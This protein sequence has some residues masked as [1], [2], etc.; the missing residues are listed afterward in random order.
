MDMEQIAR[1][2]QLREVEVRNRIWMSPMAQY[3]ATGDGCLTEWHLLHYG[4]RAVGGVGMVMVESTAIGPGDR[5]T[6]VDPGIWSEAQVDSHRKV[7]DVIRRAGAVPA[8]QLQ[9]AGRK[10]SHRVPWERSGQNSPVAPEE[11]GWIPVAPS[12]IPFGKL[13]V[14]RV[15]QRAEISMVID[16]FARAAVNAHDAGYDVVEVHA[17][18]GYLLHQFLSPLSNRRVDEYGGSLENRMRFPLAA[19]R[20]VRNEFPSNKPVF[21]RVSTND[22]ASGGFDLAEAIEFAQC[23]R[24]L[25]IDLLDV[26]SGG[27]LVDAPPPPKPALNVKSADRIRQDAGIRVAPVGQIGD[28]SVL[29]DVFCRTEVDA[30]FLGRPLLRDPYLVLRLLAG[31]PHDLWPMQY[32]RAL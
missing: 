9:A 25:D 1:P 12:A 21:F 16:R 8:V 19:A 17:A 6:L 26:T 5:C 29:E 3:S 31:D 11:G 28:P 10:S 32:H 18:H 4:A 20:A 13:A 14:P 15:L 27:L 24:E 23:L 7:T 2:V 22:W 30:V